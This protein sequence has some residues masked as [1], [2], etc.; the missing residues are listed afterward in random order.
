[1]VVAS[2]F[3][4]VLVVNPSRMHPADR[5]DVATAESE[6]GV[7]LPS[8]YAAYVQQLGEGALGHLIRVYPPQQVRTK[9]L[10]WRERVQQFWFWDTSDAGAAVEALQQRGVLLADTFD[11][12]ELCF[13]PADPETLYVL[14]RDEEI[15]HCMESGFLAALDWM[16][17][18][19]L[20][21]W[22][23]G[24]TFEAWANRVELS[25]VAPGQLPQAAS[26]VEA[27]GEHSHGVD[28]GDRRTFFL[29]SIQGRLSLYQFPDETLSIDLS[30]DET[31]SAEEIDR[32]LMVIAG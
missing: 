11:G 25:K 26:L 16:L 32:L 3:D 7:R 1:V 14:P 12:D 5:E 9:T 13:D 27:L 24:W 28:L 22:V 6:L 4:D 23:E 21:P 8:G 19:V 31:V 15:A 20:N 30:C 18:G 29:P 10:E 2:S 17:S